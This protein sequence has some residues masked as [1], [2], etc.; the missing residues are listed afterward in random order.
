MWIELA[1]PGRARARLAASN[2]ALTFSVADDGRGFDPRTTKMGAGLQN[3]A[4][5]LSALG[6]GLEV[7]STPGSGTIVSGVIPVQLRTSS[8]TDP[9]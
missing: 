7:E 4:D 8:S 2:G 1:P 3:M 6:G 5:R 9:G